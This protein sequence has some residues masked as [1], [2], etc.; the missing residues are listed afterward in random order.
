MLGSGPT[1]SKSFHF[2]TSGIANSHFVITEIPFV[3]GHLG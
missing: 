3:F 2:A 1:T